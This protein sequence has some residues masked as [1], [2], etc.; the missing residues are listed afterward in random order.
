MLE[1]QSNNAAD[2]KTC[3]FITKRLQDR[4]FPVN[5]AKFLIT[6]FFYRTPLVVASLVWTADKQTMWEIKWTTKQKSAFLKV[7]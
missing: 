1:S 2:L 5:I 7:C 3:H 4:Y 6:A